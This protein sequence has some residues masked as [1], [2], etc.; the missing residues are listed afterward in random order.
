MDTVAITLICICG[1]I[2]LVNG[3]VSY[4]VATSDSFDPRQKYIQC[5]LIWLL[6]IV[7]ATVAYVFTREPKM[8]GASGYPT[9]NSLYDNDNVGMDNAAGDYFGG[10][11]H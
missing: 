10:D 11:H 5:A 1:A 3:F 2:V 7:G 8:S 4:C 9:D 6:P